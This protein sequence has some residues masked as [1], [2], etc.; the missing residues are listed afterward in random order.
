M[1]IKI[2]DEKPSPQVAKQT[3]CTNCGVRLEYVPSDTRTEIR[4]DYTGD[5]DSYRV[6][7]CPKCKHK[8]T[9]GFH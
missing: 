6:I 9:V 2:I 1:A 3:V 4:R 8:L 5:A 7:D